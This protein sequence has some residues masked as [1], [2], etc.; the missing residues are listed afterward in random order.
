MVESSL[1]KI[2]GEDKPATHRLPDRRRLLQSLFAKHGRGPKPATPQLIERF[3]EN[4]W[5]ELDLRVQELSLGQQ[6]DN[7]AYQFGKEALVLKAA[8]RR[9]QRLH[10]QKNPAGHLLV[11]GDCRFVHLC[12]AVLRVSSGKR[13]FRHGDHQGGGVFVEWRGRRLRAGEISP[14]P[15]VR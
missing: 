9:D 7:N 12:P 14:K 5:K 10:E 13:L 1:E 2:E 4:Q 11:F 6:K 15:T 8:D 3:L